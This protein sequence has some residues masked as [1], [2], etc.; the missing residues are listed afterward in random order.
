MSPEGKTAAAIAAELGVSRQAVYKRLK[1]DNW[2][3]A[4]LTRFTFTVNKTV[5]YTDEGERLIKSVFV[6]QSVNQDSENVNQ[7]V[8][9]VNQ[10]VNQDPENVNQN[11]NH[12]NQ[13]V[14]QDDSDRVALI[15]SLHKRLED[16][17][18]EL[19]VLRSQLIRKDEQITELQAQAAQLT[20]TLDNTVMALT[21]AQVLHAADKQQQL[22]TDSA[23]PPQKLSFWERLRAGRSRKNET[24][25]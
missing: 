17:D 9:H 1:N 12:V 25:T 13:S 5:Y 3:T 19:E 8:N 7:N 2:L 22:L 18:R 15:D 20:R 11:V 24:Q 14:N 6:N 10:S 21:A 23:E 16:K 4:E